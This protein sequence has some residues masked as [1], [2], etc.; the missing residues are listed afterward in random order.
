MDLGVQDSSS[1]PSAFAA[2]EGIGGIARS[3]LSPHFAFMSPYSPLPFDP[4]NPSL[5]SFFHC[6]PFPWISHSFTGVTLPGL[7][8]YVASHS[9]GP[10]RPEEKRPQLHCHGGKKE[11]EAG[12]ATESWWHFVFLRKSLSSGTRFTGPIKFLH[13]N[14]EARLCSSRMEEVALGEAYLKERGTLSSDWCASARRVHGNQRA[15]CPALDLS[16][17]EG[18]QPRAY[19]A[20]P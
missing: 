16:C 12:R 5:F 11:R 6:I 2:A 20:G 19:A 3:G 18:E 13:R 8:R 17:S 14:V 9:S 7:C 1:S 4:L 15:P 10:H